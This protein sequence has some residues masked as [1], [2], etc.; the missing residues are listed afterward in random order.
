MEKRNCCTTMKT[1][2]RSLKPLSKLDTQHE[3]LSSW[4]SS[5]EMG[6]GAGRIPNCVDPTTWVTYVAEK[7]QRD[8]PKVM[9]K[10][11]D[12]QL[13]PAFDWHLYVMH[14]YTHSQTHK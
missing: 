13:R 7:Q 2:F 8:F 12:Q 6:G 11:K 10:G 3:Y 9:V 4:Q 1:M 14:K 5:R